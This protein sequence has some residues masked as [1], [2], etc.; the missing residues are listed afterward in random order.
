MG[1][2]VRRLAERGGFEPPVEVY[3]LQQISRAD[4]L[5]LDMAEGYLTCA[6]DETQ[7]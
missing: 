6:D 1:R 2:E 7:Y 3:P 5:K 4:D